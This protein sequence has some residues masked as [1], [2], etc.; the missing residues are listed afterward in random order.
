ML[1]I[2][3]GE[4]VSLFHIFTFIPKKLVDISFMNFHSIHVHSIHVHSIHGYEVI[5]KNMEPFHHE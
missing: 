2:I 5:H 1:L 3:C 4:N